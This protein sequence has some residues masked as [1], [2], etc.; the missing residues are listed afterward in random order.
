MNPS[1]SKPTAINAIISTAI[2]HNPTDLAGATSSGGVRRHWKRTS[3]SRPLK[4]CAVRAYRYDLFFSPPRY[5]KESSLLLLL[6]RFC[7][8]SSVGSGK[9]LIGQFCRHR[10]NVIGFVMDLAPGSRS[11]VRVCSQSFAENSSVAAGLE[12]DAIGSRYCFG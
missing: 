10:K 8:Y 11:I 6:M 12:P 9:M 1:P 3:L 4:R 2:A 7:A 5:R